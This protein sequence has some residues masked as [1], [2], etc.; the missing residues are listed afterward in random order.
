MTRLTVP[1]R[2]SLKYLAIKAAK[3]NQLRAEL[4]AERK[5]RKK[6]KRAA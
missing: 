6:Q 1:T 5:A 2:S 4:K 3:H